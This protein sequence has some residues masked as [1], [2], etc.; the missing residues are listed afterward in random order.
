M[1]WETNFEVEFN[2]P[3]EIAETILANLLLNATQHSGAGSIAIRE[4]GDGL[5]MSNP[6]CDNDEPVGFGFGLEIV[7]RLG[8]WIGWVVE[9]QRSGNSIVPHINSSGVRGVA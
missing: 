7:R 8:A 6:C 1:S 9:V 4:S 3:A 5:E 2:G